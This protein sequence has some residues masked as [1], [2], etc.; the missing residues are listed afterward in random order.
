MQLSN[1]ALRRL[2]LSLTSVQHQHLDPRNFRIDQALGTTEDRLVIQRQAFTV[3]HYVCT[4][5]TLTADPLQP[6]TDD[7]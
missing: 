7:R 3:R 4:S 5:L 1:L 2:E 6:R